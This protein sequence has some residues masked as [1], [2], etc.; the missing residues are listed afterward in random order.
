MTDTAN[1]VK[2]RIPEKVNPRLRLG[3]HLHHDPRSREYPVADLLDTT[4][5]LTTQVWARRTYPFDQGDLGS[6]TGNACEGML[7]T[8]PFRQAHHRYSERVAVKLYMLATQLD[9]FGGVYPP[10]DTGSSTLGVLKAAKQLGAIASYRWGFST[11]DCLRTLSQ[12]GPVIIGINWY[13][14]FDHPHDHGLL[15]IGGSIRGGHELELLGIDVERRE[16]RGVNSWGRAWGDRGRFSLSFDTLDRLLHE[17]G[18][19]G[20]GVR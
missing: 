3:R 6:C 17:Q 1:H 9:G 5:P 14:G 11:D 20:T 15:T 18:E 19:C 16:V 10:D 7:A 2:A 4:L 8:V 13:E 12:L